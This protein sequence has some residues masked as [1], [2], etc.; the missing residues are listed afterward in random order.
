MDIAEVMELSG[1]YVARRRTPS[2]GSISLERGAEISA[3]MSGTSQ[4]RS[5]GAAG[6]HLSPWVL[7]MGGAY[8]GMA[9]A[10]RLPRAGIRGRL[11]ADQRRS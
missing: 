11:L 4:F 10:L 5:Q 9:A 2:P 1:R 8:T 3:L 6:P 7:V